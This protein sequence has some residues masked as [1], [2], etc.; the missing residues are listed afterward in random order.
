VRFSSLPT[1]QGDYGIGVEIVQH[2]M[3]KP[4][5]KILYQGSDYAKEFVRAAIDATM[6]GAKW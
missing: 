1:G 6:D 5:E 3:G 4:S 2:C